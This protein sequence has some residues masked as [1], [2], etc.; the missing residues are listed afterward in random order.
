MNQI[1]ICF[2]FTILIGAVYS[3]EIKD[4]QSISSGTSFGMCRGYCQQSINFM[5]NPLEILAVKRVTFENGN[6]IEGFEELI[7]KLRNLREDY[8]TQLESF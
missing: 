8:L 4:I 2:L 5:I 1:S 6:T 3:L 7:E